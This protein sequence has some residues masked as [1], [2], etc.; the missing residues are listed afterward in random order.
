[1]QQAKIRQ[2][3][4][5]FFSDPTEKPDQRYDIQLWLYNIDSFCY[6][7]FIACLLCVIH[8]PIQENNNEAG[9]VLSF[10]AYKPRATKLRCAK[11]FSFPPITIY[12]LFEAPTHSDRNPV[13]SSSLLPGLSLNSRGLKS[14]RESGEQ[15]WERNPILTASSPLPYT[16]GK[17]S[18]LG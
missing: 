4:F 8:S 17:P 16:L 11:T 12:V 13:S 6:P 3:F 1:M 15:G 10:D 14:A 7:L 2:D 18:S 9:M 5:F